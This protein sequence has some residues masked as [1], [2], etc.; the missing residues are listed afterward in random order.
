MKPLRSALRLPLALALAAA[1]PGPECYAAMARIVSIPITR[2]VNPGAGVGIPLLP[3]LNAIPTVATQDLARTALPGV[4]LFTTINASLAL[5]NLL[6]FFPLDGHHV[7]R[8]LLKRVLPQRAFGALEEFYATGGIWAWVPLISF[9]AFTGHFGLFT[10]AANAVT[11]FLLGG[12][13]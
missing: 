2:A 5:F 6:P 3:G 8:P 4:A 12:A 9:L 1:L 7:V 13:P 11:G 10:H